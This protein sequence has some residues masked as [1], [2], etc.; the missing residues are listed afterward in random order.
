[1]KSIVDM[2]TV[3]KDHIVLDSMKHLIGY[4]LTAV[5]VHQSH[6]NRLLVV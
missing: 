4:P 2:P 3:T 6:K 1:M 5:G